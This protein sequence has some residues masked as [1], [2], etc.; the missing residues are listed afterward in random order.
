MANRNRRAQEPE[1]PRAPVRRQ[2]H[3]QQQDPSRGNAQDQDQQVQDHPEG[4][5]EGQDQQQQITGID[6]NQGNAISAGQHNI[7]VPP[8]ASIKPDMKNQEWERR[9]QSIHRV[10]STL[11]TLA[12]ACD[13]KAVIHLSKQAVR[14]GQHLLK[15]KEFNDFFQAKFTVK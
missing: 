3:F 9:V 12:E 11:P 10:I 8:V 2:V 1:Q 6:G 7:L 14:C 5:A 13:S 15:Y 4:N